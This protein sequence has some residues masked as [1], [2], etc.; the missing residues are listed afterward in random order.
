MTIPR[1]ERYDLSAEQVVGHE[2]ELAALRGHAECARAGE[3]TLVVVEGPRGIGKTALLRRFARELD[4]FRVLHAQCDRDEQDVPMAMLSQLTAGFAATPVFGD[5]LVNLLRAAQK[6]EPVALLIDDVTAADPESVVALGYVLRRLFDTRVLIVVTARVKDAMPGWVWGDHESTS[7]HW[8]RLPGLTQSSTRLELVGLEPADLARMLGLPP[9]PGAAI[10]AQRLHH[11]TNGNPA[12]AMALLGPPPH[13]GDE[14]TL[15]VPRSI[16]ASVTAAM[17]ALPAASR[18][19]LEALAVLGVPSPLPQMARVAGVQELWSAVEPLLAAEFVRW[20]E[21]APAAIEIAHPLQQEVVYGAVPAHRRAELHRAAAAAATGDE[22]LRHQVAAA[23]EVDLDLAEE[24]EGAAAKAL[25]AGEPDRAATYLLWAADLHPSPAEGERLR[26]TAATRLL[27]AGSTDRALTLRR[28]VESGTP[29]A[30]QRCAQGE[31]ALLDAALVT[32]QCSL[33]EALALATDADSWLIA[34]THLALANVHAL[35]G[36]GRSALQHA[37]KAAAELQA[38]AVT[39]DAAH[40]AMVRGHLYA[41]GP[42]SALAHVRYV[43]EWLT[44][45]RGGDHRLSSLRAVCELLAYDTASSLRSARRAVR[46]AADIGQVPWEEDPR[47]T[48][49][50]ARYLVGEWSLAETELERLSA[51]IRSARVPWFTLSASACAVLLAAGRGEFDRAA[52]IAADMGREFRAGAP[53]D[54]EIYVGLA[55]AGL[56]QARGDYRAMLVALSF[57]EDDLLA[58]QRAG[59]RACAWRSWWLPLR[60]EGLIGES[61]L[62]Q[63]AYESRMLSEL[64]EEIPPLRVVAGRLAAWL[65][66]RRGGLGPACALYEEVTDKASVD[67]RTPPLHLAMALLSHGRAMRLAGRRRSAMRVLRAAREQFIALGAFAFLPVCEKEF[68]RC[69]LT[70]P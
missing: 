61:Q 67:T 52:R 3:L 1:Q 63:A 33:G 22:A 19:L 24:L 34:R 13:S 14:P 69:G 45:A 12:Q 27:W 53:A 31:Y 62:A 4:R 18:M 41:T 11:H 54:H 55:E 5:E 16:I 64:A 68:A 39:T 40:A 57:L 23:G 15:A 47:L 43:S 38:D 48:T 32:A 2:H 25:T 30:V 8:Q 46:A 29:S 9:T 26:A 10:L 44:D 7:E 42:A 49:A 51:D 36:D 17:A 28:T 35:R 50:F 66:E 21:S 6:A 58:E 20:Q 65:V 37:G 59:G 70:Q 56:A 60:V